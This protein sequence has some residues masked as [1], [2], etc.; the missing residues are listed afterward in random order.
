MFEDSKSAFR[1]KTIWGGLMAIAAPLLGLL[2]YSLSPADQAEIVAAVSAIFG[3]V[4]GLITIYG[5]LT[6]TKRIG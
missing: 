6:A 1:S 4:G 2:G 3:A 5:R